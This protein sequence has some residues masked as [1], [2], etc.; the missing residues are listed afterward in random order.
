MSTS[1]ILFAAS[2]VAT[3]SPSW[4]TLSTINLDSTD[5]S[6]KVN[7]LDCASDSS[8]GIR[9]FGYANNGGLNDAYYYKYDSSGYLYGVLR[10]YTTSYQVVGYGVTLNSSDMA[11][12]A[13]AQGVSGASYRTTTYRIGDDFS[14]TS[15]KN[16]YLVD[17]SQNSYAQKVALQPT[18]TNYYTVGYA[19][20]G[21]FQRGFVIK[22]DN[23]GTSLWT[24]SVDGPYG[25]SY[26]YAGVASSSNLYA[27]GRTTVSSGY[28]KPWVVKFSSSGSKTWSNIYSTGSTTHS[29]AYGVVEDEANGYIYVSGELNDPTYSKS[30]GMFLKI[31]ASSGALV[32]S[33]L[34]RSGPSAY[35]A[36]F[37]KATKDSSGNIYVCGYYIDANSN[38]RGIIVKYNSSG[39]VQFQRELYT[40]NTTASSSQVFFQSIAVTDEFIYVVGTSVIPGASLYASQERGTVCQFKIDGSDTGEIGPFTYAA[41]SLIEYSASPSATSSGSTGNTL[42]TGSTSTNTDLS[43][44][45]YVIS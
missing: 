37:R 20:D 36:Y 27:V 42:S 29:G 6:Q 32:F 4:I 45:F 19:S 12:I 40:T 26:F 17:P 8:G 10:L 30:V 11:Y 21:S 13:T 7:F 2:G 23:A 28:Y 44:S 22:Y 14:V 16:A 33:K 34:L 25:S 35:D 3:G 39:V 38:Y 18:T 15:S 9:A 31:D 1:N 5:A 24:A 41:S 43:R